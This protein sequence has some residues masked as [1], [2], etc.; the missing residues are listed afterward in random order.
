MIDM[1]YAG[2][3]TVEEQV[4]ARELIAAKDADIE[5]WK[6]AFLNGGTETMMKQLAARELVI[7]Q[8]RE[9]IGVW[10]RSETDDEHCSAEAGLIAAMHLKPTTEALDAYVAEKC[11][12]QSN[13]DNQVFAKELERKIAEAVK[14]EREECAKVC[15]GYSMAGSNH[16]YLCMRDIRARGGK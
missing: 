6:R 3:W 2:S 9:A 5:K 7:Q 16:A 4:E 10:E 11:S 8:M 1:D 13:F 14:K 15:E 12:D